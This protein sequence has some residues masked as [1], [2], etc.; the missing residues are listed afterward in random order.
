VI[1]EVEEPSPELEDYCRGKGCAVV[2][3]HGWLELYY[4]LQKLNGFSASVGPDEDH[5]TP[6]RVNTNP[7]FKFHASH[8]LITHSYVPGDV[9]GCHIAAEDAWE[10]IKGVRGRAEVTIYPAVQCIK[11][12]ALMERLGHVLAWVH[13]GHGDEVKGLQQAGDSIFK[14]AEDWV[15][16][17]AGY[18]SSL[19]VAVFSSCHS[20]SVAR[21]FAEAGVGVTI[22]F[23]HKVYKQVCVEL[24]SRVVKATLNSNG[25]RQAILEAFN[26]GRKVLEIDDK[27]AGPVAFWA[28]H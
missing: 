22:G 18:K 14:P 27:D 23:A 15:N 4:T 8:L 9:S 6:V 10:L 20:E 21:R 7:T 24:T 16:S 25:S 26:I 3:F 5:A 12:A 2:R 11:L 1:D 13:I 28:R 17:F 19:A